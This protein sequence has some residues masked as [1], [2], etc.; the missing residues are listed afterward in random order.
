MLFSGYRTPGSVKVGATPIGTNAA[1]QYTPNA[2]D[3]LLYRNI[4]VTTLTP[5]ST[6]PSTTSTTVTSVPVAPTVGQSVTYTATV[7]TTSQG[8]PTGTVAFSDAS[9]TLCAAV[10]LS[11]SSPDTATCTTTYDGS[12]VS[13]SYGGDV[14]SAASSGSLDFAPP[15][16]TAVSA[17][18]GSDSALVSWT[19]PSV[20]GGSAITGYTV[21]ASGDGGS[22]T[23]TS[24][25]TS[26]TVSGLANGT[27]YTFTVT[28]T[29]GAGTSPP[30]TASTPVTPTGTPD[31]PTNVTVT[32]GDGQATVSWTP[33]G[34]EGWGSSPTP[35][36]ASHRARPPSSAPT[37]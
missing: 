12:A 19:A 3:P 21:T 36:P 14:D 34:A 18:A 15:A 4:L 28:A 37:R 26:C 16:P 8:N 32:G 11:V 25:T 5:E 6:V 35:P 20:T 1:A 29:N 31:A 27:S 17:T 7:T 24:A 30:S 22:E 23:C 13:T 2:A 33:G 10:A 9:G